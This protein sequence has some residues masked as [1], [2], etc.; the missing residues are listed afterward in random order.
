MDIGSCTMVAINRLQC[1]SN[2]SAT[3]SNMKLVH[4][5]RGGDWAGCGSAQSPPCC[6]KCIQLACDGRRFRVAAS[7]GA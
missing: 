2:Y 4:W 1:R 5:P 7:S 3:L 6:T